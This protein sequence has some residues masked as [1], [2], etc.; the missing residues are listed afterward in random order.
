MESIILNCCSHKS[1]GFPDPLPAKASAFRFRP[2]LHASLFYLPECK[3][4]TLWWA[5]E[6]CT[7]APVTAYGITASVVRTASLVAPDK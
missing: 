5:F 3:T 6:V 2:S 1:V 4:S 7:L